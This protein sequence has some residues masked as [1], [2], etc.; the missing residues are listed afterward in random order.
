MTTRNLRPV[1]QFEPDDRAAGENHSGQVRMAYRLA[2]RYRDQLLYVHRLGVERGWHVWDGRRWAEDERGDA[3]KAVLAILRDALADSIG[4][5][6]LRRDVTRCESAAGIKGVLAIAAAL[7]PF[8]HTAAELDPDPYLLN[9]QNGTLD[10]RTLELRDHDPHDRISKVTRASYTAGTDTG[11]WDKFLTRVLPDEEI[12]GFLQRLAGVGLVGRV[13]EHVL[14]ILIG[15]GD[16]GKGTFYKALGHTLGNYAAMAE[17]DLFMHREGAHPTGEMDLWGVRWVAVSESDKDK[18]LAEATMK[19]LT[20]GDTIRARYMHKDFVQFEPSHTPILVTNHLPKVSGDDPAIW[21]R[22]RVIPFDVVIPAA[23]K[24]G[25]LEETLQLNADAILSWAV[26]GYADYTDR[27]GLDEPDKVTAATHRYQLDSDALGRFIND[28][29]LTNP[30]AYA[31]TGELFERWCQWATD[32][33]TEHGSRKVF[34]QSLDRRGF[35]ARKGGRAG[36]QRPGIGLL[37]AENGD[38]DV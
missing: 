10:L 4:D 3:T 1:Q 24:D 2:H 11:T 25:H 18:R 17:P 7:K 38:N 23:E 37:A 16:N 36:R 8:A 29:C 13:I 5:K 27:G 31:T 35:P 12:R 33:G 26:M 28:C 21:R 22:L 32:D 6:V 19:R 14:G 30:H 15:V 20:G 34:G 9:C